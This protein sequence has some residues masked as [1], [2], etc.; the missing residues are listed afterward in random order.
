[1]IVVSEDEPDLPRVLA[2][3]RNRIRSQ[4]LTIAQNVLNVVYE[5]VRKELPHDRSGTKRLT[6]TLS[7]GKHECKIPLAA[8]V[9]NHV[10]VCRHQ[11]LL[12]GYLI[13]RLIADGTLVGA[14]SID[15]NMRAFRWREILGNFLSL[16][17]ETRGG[18][19]WARFTVT[20]GTVYIVDAAQNY[21]GP[22]N[23]VPQDPESWRTWF[24]PEDVQ[25]KRKEPLFDELD[26]TIAIA[27]TLWAIWHFL[28]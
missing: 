26:K 7:A 22:L 20:D 10:G 16:D 2:D 28:L 8:F 9:R 12:A 17:F 6:K 14:V 5:T 27:G 1:M 15:R 25:P 3:V 19:Q 24:R 23:D 21:C 13:E 18:H 4:R 11:A